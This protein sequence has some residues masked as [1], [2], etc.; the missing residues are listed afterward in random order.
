MTDLEM[1][2]QMS[3]GNARYSSH[4]TQN[5]LIEIC[6]EAIL[7]QIVAPANRSTGFSILADETDDISGTEQSS[8]AV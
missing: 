2:L 4:R 8:F 6:Q 7:T 1:H 5:E 3:S